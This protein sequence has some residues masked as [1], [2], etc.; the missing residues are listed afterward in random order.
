VVLVTHDMS[1]VREYCDRAV[2]ID[3]GVVMA[4]GGPEEVAQAYQRLFSGSETTETGPE[5]RWGD[6]RMKVEAASA[7]VTDKS[8]TIRATFTA[9][10]DLEPALYG[11]SMHDSVHT[12]VLESNT[13]RL[14]FKTKALK[15]GQ[16]VTLEWKFANV[17]RTGTYT[18]NIACCDQSARYY[19]D[20]LNRAVRFEIIKPTETAGA[21][22]LP[23]DIKERKG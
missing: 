1:A 4:S 23:V 7:Q 5:D 11:F 10:A 19:Y 16:S 21:V 22:D 15:A 8:V 20:W 3:K 14:K 12:N 18:V 17:L 2:M 9:H 13:K 6:G